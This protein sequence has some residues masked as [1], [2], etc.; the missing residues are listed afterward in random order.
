MIPYLTVSVFLVLLNLATTPRDFW[1]IYPVLGWGLGVS[2]E[3]IKCS[4]SKSCY[5]KN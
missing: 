4:R 5:F 1:S 2:I 3:G